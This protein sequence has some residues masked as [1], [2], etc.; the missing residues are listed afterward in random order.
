MF[1]PTFVTC[2]SA[3][4]GDNSFEKQNFA[5]D[6][7]IYSHIFLTLLTLS[8][9]IPTRLYEDSLIFSIVEIAEKQNVYHLPSR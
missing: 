3:M 5:N 8:L 9:S 2:G 4:R 1:L 7:S 6:A